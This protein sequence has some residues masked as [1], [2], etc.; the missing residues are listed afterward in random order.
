MKISKWQSRRSQF[1]HDWL[2]NQY[3][4]ALDN[5]LNILDQRIEGDDESEADFIAR[6]L[7]TWQ[8]KSVEVRSLIEGFEREMSPVT[9][10]DL[11]PLVNFDAETREWLGDL[12]HEL[13]LIRYAVRRQLVA[14]A[15][16]SVENADA[17]YESLCRALSKY[18]N[19]DKRAPSY[20]AVEIR[21]F[22]P[23]FGKFRQACF[24]V[25]QAI[26]QFP[27]EILI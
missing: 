22:R 15:S 20:N 17:A 1:N 18:K 24:N 25:A 2:K 10:F 23:L 16:L 21:L 11:L 7:P 26:E 14:Q 13:W 27:S 4:T 8:H 6:V 12:T 19:S 5:F 3:L 9:F